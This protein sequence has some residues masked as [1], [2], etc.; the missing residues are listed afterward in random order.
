MSTM[1]VTLA[2]RMVTLVVPKVRAGED[3]PRLD[4]ASVPT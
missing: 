4:L 2:D 1:L 3:S